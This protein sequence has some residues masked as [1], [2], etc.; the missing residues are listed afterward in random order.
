M[1]SSS[2]PELVRERHQQ[3]AADARLDVLLGDVARPSRR[4]A[5]ASVAIEARPSAA[6]SARQVRCR[7]SSAS[8]RASSTLPAHENGD[9]IG[10]PSTLTRA[11]SASAAI[12]AVSAESMPP[13][14]P[15][16]TSREAALAGV[17]AHAEHQRAD[18]LLLRRSQA[19]RDRRARRD[20]ASSRSTTSTSLE[21][22]ARARTS[23]RAPITHAAPSKT[24]VVAA[25][26]G[27]RRRRTRRACARAGR[28]SPR[29]RRC[30]PTANGEAD[31][32]NITSAP[33][34]ARR[35]SD[36]GGSAAGCQSRSRS[37]RPRRR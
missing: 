11:P 26:P 20:A 23:P 27:S 13:E 32:F 6:R 7:G 17:V 2:A 8:A 31:R 30:L 24:V 25:R 29:A 37:T 34:R 12:T 33:S 5:G 19:R 28:A 3:L 1:V 9:G 21:R 15:S 10:T 16:S 18:D 35:R 22:A 4:T 14:R 36:R